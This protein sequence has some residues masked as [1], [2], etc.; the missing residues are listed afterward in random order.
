V[1]FPFSFFYLFKLGVAKFSGMF[2]NIGVCWALPPEGIG[3][4]TLVFFFNLVLNNHFQTIES[5][6]LKYQF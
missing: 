6:I 3:I 5:F 4:V 2:A 1:F